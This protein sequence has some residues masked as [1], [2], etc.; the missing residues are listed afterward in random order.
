MCVQVLNTDGSPSTWFGG[1]GQLILSIPATSAS[2]ATALATIGTS[3]L[4][5]SGPCTES[6]VQR[7]CVAALNVLGLSATFNGGQPVVDT[8]NIAGDAIPMAMA[9][10]FNG[11]TLDTDIAVAGACG[12]DFCAV[13]YQQ[14]GT[15]ITS[16]GV[17]GVKLQEMN[18]GRLTDVSESLVRQPD[19]R[20][21]AAGTCATRACMARFNADGTLD[22]TFA[23]GGIYLDAPN[24]SRGLGSRMAMDGTTIVHVTQ[25]NTG[26]RITRLLD[27]GAPDPAWGAGTGVV[28]PV[29]TTGLFAGH[30]AGVAVIGGGSLLIGFAC[31]TGPFSNDFCVA[32]LTPAGAL[33]TTFN[34]GGVTPGLRQESFGTNDVAASM[35]MD[36]SSIVVAGTCGTAV[37]NPCVMR[38]TSAG[39]PDTTFNGTGKRTLPLGIANA[40]FLA[41]SVSAGKTT[42]GGGCTPSV[43]EDFCVTR[44]NANGSLDTTFNGTGTA[45]LSMGLFASRVEALVADG[46]GV[47]AA[48][49][50][51][52]DGAGLARDLCLARFRE[53]GIIDI[54][55]N[56][57]GLLRSQLAM[58]ALAQTV[59]DM[60]RDG[61]RFVASMGNCL[62]D[63]GDGFSDFCVAAYLQLPA[64]LPGAPF[65][66]GVIA[67]DTTATVSFVPPA[68]NGGSSITS[69]TATCGTQSATGASSPLVVTGLL[70]GVT[71]GCSVTATNS[72][73][74]GPGSDPPVSVRPVR[75]AIVTLTASVNPSSATGVVSFFA[76]I[77]GQG[78]TGSVEFRLA[79][80]QLVP[81][82]SLPVVVSS[83]VA[84]CFSNTFSTPGTFSITA[85]YSGDGANAPAISNTLSHTVIATFEQLSVTKLGAGSATVTSAPGGIDCGATCT[86][87]FATNASVTLTAVPA[88]GTV[89]QSWTGCT[90]MSGNDCVM[91]MAVPR[92][93]QVTLLLQQYA[94]TV[95]KAGGGS[96]AV[97]SSPA[98]IDCGATCVANYGAGSV[99]TLSASAAAGSTFTGWSGACTGMAACVVT[100]DG[101]KA[102]IATFTLSPL[103]PNPPRLGNI[104][105]RGQVLTGN[106]VMIGGF[107]IGGSANK[108]V[109][110]RAR[111]PSLV[112]F[113][114]TNALANPTLQLFLGQNAIATNDDFGTAPNL[115]A[116]Q[117]SGFA[118]DNPLESAILAN[119]APG[120]YTAIVSGVGGGTGVGII[121]VFEVDQFTTPLVNISTRGKVLTGNDV[122]IGGFV[123]QGSGPQAVVVRARGPSLVPFGITNALANP[124]LQLVRSSDQATLATNDDW[125]SASNAAA[126]TASGFAPSEALEAAILITLDPGAYTAI[127][128]GVGGGTGV[129]I[130]EVFAAP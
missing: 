89:V 33:D 75:A 101:A 23:A 56:G 130:V 61:A 38:L 62:P 110:V 81:G 25:S 46:T 77:A 60:V 108:T 28:V 37:K 124:A 35:T 49:S 59:T 82:C 51:D 24:T 58:G 128:T 40:S 4:Y 29:L 18:L 2:S 57:T 31:E 69:Y 3:A 103:P 121:E 129:A 26:M 126:V 41:V 93:V 78:P 54:D 68:S 8:L 76:S 30:V 5:V 113:G 32:K 97:T 7:F 116:L 53:D 92:A 111:G 87:Q 36:G 119:L 21:V 1:S 122:M 84:T 117:A 79:G 91:F 71:V 20:I 100:L 13:R 94:V 10:V 14:T 43:K 90:V 63:N 65:I 102:A 67:G 9:A 44:L 112:P 80:G 12:G 96:G 105:T 66:T 17:L 114:I 98:G 22:T 73:G 52:N 39:I 83:G 107:V 106:D 109:V 50:C 125:G 74:T 15:R 48:G 120:A 127:V 88:I 34:A 123:I 47:V 11:I 6:G 118:P 95:S 85:H 64:S 27:N 19:G 70:N 104:S 16:F 45:T 55:F 72:A 42:L 115:A 99:V 86:A